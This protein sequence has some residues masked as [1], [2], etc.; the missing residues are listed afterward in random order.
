ML[1]EEN[2]EYCTVTYEEVELTLLENDVKILKIDFSSRLRDSQTRQTT[3]VGIWILGK[4]RL[5]PLST[6]VLVKGISSTLAFLKPGA[7]APASNAAPVMP[8]I[9][10]DLLWPDN[11]SDNKIPDLSQCLANVWVHLSIFLF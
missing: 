6:V 2:N 5:S 3:L 9:D 10:D 7:P 11:D 1:K 8:F 4:I